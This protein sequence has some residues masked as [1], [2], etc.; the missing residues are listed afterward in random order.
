V[1]RASLLTDEKIHPNDDVDMS[2]PITI[3]EKIIADLNDELLDIIE[4]YEEDFSHYVETYHGLKI[5][6]DY[7]PGKF[8]LNW[9]DFHGTYEYTIQNLIHHIMW[10][11]DYYKRFL[12]EDQLEEVQKVIEDDR[13]NIYKSSDSKIQSTLDRIYETVI[14]ETAIRFKD[15]EYFSNE[16]FDDFIRNAGY[17][18][19]KLDKETVTNDLSIPTTNLFHDPEW[20]EMRES[21]LDDQQVMDL[22][23]IW[24]FARYKERKE[25]VWYELY[26]TE[27]SEYVE[28]GEDLGKPLDAE[29]E[30]MSLLLHKLYLGVQFGNFIDHGQ[31]NVWVSSKEEL[32]TFDRFLELFESCY[33]N[34]NTLEYDEEY[35]QQKIKSLES[36]ISDRGLDKAFEDLKSADK[37][38]GVKIDSYEADRLREIF[39][40]KNTQ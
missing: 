17:D 20:P 34:P 18:V 6:V 11:K 14:I 28:D 16:E 35:F 12:S 5:R 26:V 31:I 19:P 21:D 22:S 1:R 33:V 3:V 24:Q 25:G 40:F 29:E 8:Y 15:R 27:R 4:D 23:G 30:K 2:Q 39:G 13:D 9:V 36:I 37:I 10:E 32:A 38:G 7:G